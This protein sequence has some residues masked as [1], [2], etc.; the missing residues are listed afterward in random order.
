MAAEARLFLTRRVRT[1]LLVLV[2]LLPL[3][4]GAGAES[5]LTPTVVEPPAPLSP[6][7]AVTSFQPVP[8][9]D[10]ADLSA[11][12]DA[13]LRPEAPA[14]D[15]EEASEFAPPPVEEEELGGLEQEL[16]PPPLT[17]ETVSRLVADGSGELG[18]FLAEKAILGSRDPQ[19]VG[20]WMQV[21]AEA[22]IA[23]GEFELARDLLGLSVQRAEEAD[24]RIDYLMGTAWWAE[25]KWARARD[26]FA[27]YLAVRPD[28]PDRFKAQRAVG[29]A[30]VKLQDWQ[31]ARLILGLYEEEPGRPRPDPVLQTALADAALAL[32]H[33]EEAIWRLERVG[34]IKGLPEAEAARARSLE[35]LEESGDREALGTALAQRLADQ[36]LSLEERQTARL[37]LVRLRVASGALE[38]ALDLLEAGLEEEA[39]LREDLASTYGDLFQRYAEQVARRPRPR[40]ISPAEAARRA[41]ARDLIRLKDPEDAQE[42]REALEN[43]LTWA[44][45]NR[46]G[47]LAPDGLLDP[48]RL[49]LDDLDGS[50]RL[51]YACAYRLSDGAAEALRIL[52]AG[53]ASEKAAVLGRELL[54]ENPGPA[55]RTG[56]L[57][58]LP[59]DPAR[60]GLPLVRAAATAW[61]EFRGYAGFTARLKES[62]EAVAAEEGMAALGA[63]GVI[64]ADRAASLVAEGRGAEALPL[65]LKLAYGA[66]AEARGAFLKEDP[67]VAAA[68]ILQR[69]GRESEAAALAKAAEGRV[70]PAPVISPPLCRTT[71]S[72][73][74]SSE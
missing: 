41:H 44:R 49:G 62:L 34:G 5:A 54:G 3:A 31:G 27:R 35:L 12:P 9:T 55:A 68:L 38:A 39:T 21:R 14:D 74:S 51:A 8:E 2:F 50:E 18:L 43:L 47:L 37:G 19:E 1:Q 45:E 17:P 30:A 20:R 57:G 32:G 63:A 10:P 56:W 16:I 42:R 33:R 26:A 7:S 22:H 46:F 23:L 66:D 61:I 64:E 53:E 60:W 69:E 67:R 25:G 71:L 24:P 72:P 15:E 73:S 48:E 40:E 6:S 28:H 11:L 65:F 4:G 70:R 58:L 59:D 29:L 36:Y 52:A 13:A